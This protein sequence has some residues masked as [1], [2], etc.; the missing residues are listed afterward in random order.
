M[1]SAIFEISLIIAA[2][3]LFWLKTGWSTLFYIALGLIAFY[4]VVMVLYI[5]AKGP[6]MSLTDRLLGI[7][8]LAGWLAIAFIVMREKGLHLWGL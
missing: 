7:L 3:I 6:T 4:A 8:A 2:F 5:K 1:R